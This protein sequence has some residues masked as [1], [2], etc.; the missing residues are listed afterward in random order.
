MTMSRHAACSLLSSNN[1]T[2]YTVMRTLYGR[3]VQFLLQLQIYRMRWPTNNCHQ[4]A[5]IGTKI[6]D[7]YRISKFSG[8][9][10]L[11]GAPPDSRPGLR[12]WKGGKPYNNDIIWLQRVHVRVTL[13]LYSLI[14][15]QSEI[16]QV[17]SSTGRVSAV[18]SCAV[19]TFI[20][21]LRIHMDTAWALK[22]NNN[23]S[24]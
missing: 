13:Q 21:L 10:W 8:L 3:S 5:S 12:K 4:I 16:A 1:T 6:T 17:W 23:N 22:T 11:M 24:V 20:F 19:T 14:D 9:S 15:L 2:V 18:Y 7:A